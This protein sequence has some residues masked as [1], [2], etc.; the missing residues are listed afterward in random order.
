MS[1]YAGRTQDYRNLTSIDDDLSR[2]DIV[3]PKHDGWWAR[4]V[5][6]KANDRS[7]EIYSRQAQLKD[8]KPVGKGCPKMTLIGE[9]IRGTSRATTGVEAG[10]EECVVA[11]DI[12][13]LDGAV[14][15]ESLTYKRRL[16][17][18]ERVTAHADW[19][20]PVVTRP[21]SFAPAM[22]E[23]SVIKGGAEGLVFR[24][25]RDTYSDGTIGRLKREFTMDYVVMRLEEGKGK[26]EGMCG[27]LV[28]GLYEGGK[29]VEKLRVGGGMSNIMRMEF[30]NRP[31]EVIGQVIEVKG[32]QLFETGAMR[33]PQ[34]VRFRS[35]K[36]P[37]ECQWSK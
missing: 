14:V 35:D 6:G 33:H 11:F 15:A 18:I 29:L 3:Q 9:F 32:W 26:L 22:W 37:T 8:R 23:S 4:V 21:I 10:L 28:C 13:E 1:K 25:S 7:A 36:V 19:L 12:V 5:I 27:V 34:F 31:R 17:L 30:W 20:V 24:N 16:D 2:W